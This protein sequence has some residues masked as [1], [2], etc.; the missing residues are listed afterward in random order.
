MHLEINHKPGDG[1]TVMVVD[2]SNFSLSYDHCLCESL[3]NEGC[4]VTLARSDDVNG[5]WNI[6][7]S[8]ATWNRFYA[9]T[10]TYAKSRARGR[11]WKIAKAAE[12]LVSMKNLLHEAERLRPDIIHFQWLPIPALDRVFL[13]RL[14][15]IAPLIL[16]LHNTTVFHGGATSLH[17]LGFHSALANFDAAIAHT[18]YSKR[19][20]ID[21][22]W[23]SE[24]KI[25]VIPHGALTHYRALST[26]RSSTRGENVVLFFGSIKHYKGVDILIRAFAQ[27]PADILNTATLHIMGNP[28]A[29]TA[30][31]QQLAQNL[32][33]NRCIKW[34]LRFVEEYE[35]PP[36]F[37]EADAVV[38][39]YREIDQSGV[40][41][42]AVAFDK[43]IIA[44]NVGGIGETIRDGVHGYLVPPCDVASLTSA[45]GSVLRDPERR[46]SMETAVAA[47]REE[48]SWKKIARKTINLYRSLCG[49]AMEEHCA[50]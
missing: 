32:G 6:P 38:L 29:D 5:N 39:P 43:A 1:L 34:D 18:Q 8:Y 7:A 35:I 31:L 26:I 25:N 22:Q 16:T 49:V 45:L 30:S 42:T 21:Q 46:S 41:L 4:R 10:H 44:S 9:R 33:I 17:G 12:H 19:R 27:L 11:L 20:A 36:A 3:T 23:F 15:K 13:P 28:G 37:M 50:V 2:P 47:L 24:N 14:R 40:L 48:L